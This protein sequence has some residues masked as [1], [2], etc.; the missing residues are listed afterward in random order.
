MNQISLR[1]TAQI[2]DYGNDA[3]QKLYCLLT[4][5]T[6]PKQLLGC[7]TNFFLCN[8]VEI[9]L[10]SL[11]QIVLPLDV[12]INL[13]CKFTGTMVIT[14]IAYHQT[15]NRYLRNVRLSCRFHAYAWRITTQTSPVNLDGHHHYQR[16]GY[17][18]V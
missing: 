5:L 3:F 9:A 16:E 13:S 8:Y 17:D 1:S 12:F 6:I 14:Q 10:S 18:E 7:F 2:I 15:H 11:A 4:P